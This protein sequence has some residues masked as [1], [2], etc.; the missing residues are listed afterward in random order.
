MGIQ[1]AIS[2]DFFMKISEAKGFFLFEI[3]KSQPL[4][5]LFEYLC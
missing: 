5:V 2:T 3:I 4:S 1:Y